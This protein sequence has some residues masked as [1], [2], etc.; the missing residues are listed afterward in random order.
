MAL[1]SNSSAGANARLKP[2]T[3]IAAVVSTY[4]HDLTGAMLES[5]RD[6][7]IDCG[8]DAADLIVVLAPG[9]FEL[10]ILAQR[11]AR[12]NDVHAVL[13]F[14]LVLK[15][16]TEHDRHIAGAVAHG[17]TD[18]ALQTDT[19]VLFGLLT[20]NTL[21]Q[22]QARARRAGEGGLDKGREVARA[23]V[24]VLAGL[25]QIERLERGGRVRAEIK[26]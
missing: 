17:L 8:L 15:G 21:E 4:H 22:A 24:A 14:G 26:S 11:L 18:V 2:G 5:A 1:D 16:E 9:A 19:P 3:R 13:C 20:T 12:R 23:A 10:P 6:H 7:L 25:T